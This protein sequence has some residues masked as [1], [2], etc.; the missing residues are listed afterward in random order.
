MSKRKFTLD[1]PIP[2]RLE[3]TLVEIALTSMSAIIS[4]IFGS[5]NLIGSG[6]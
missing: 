3:S 1:L 5:K 6:S 2:P 4:L